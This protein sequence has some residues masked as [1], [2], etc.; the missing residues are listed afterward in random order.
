M[1]TAPPAEG[2]S[3][4]N[5]SGVKSPAQYRPSVVIPGLP[6]G[7]FPPTTA[8]QQPP[9]QPPAPQQPS[10][11]SGF[12]TLPASRFGQPIFKQP[13]PQQQQNPQQP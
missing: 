13:Q 3:D 7:A 12:H 4:G 2:P 5:P 8:P 10:G 9:Q 11:N 1:D 6:G